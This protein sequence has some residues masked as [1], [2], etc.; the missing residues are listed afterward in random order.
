MWCSE[1]EVSIGKSL[2]KAAKGQKKVKVPGEK[3]MVSIGL[4]CGR[5]NQKQER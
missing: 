1:I 2:K 3:K 4:P 5:Q